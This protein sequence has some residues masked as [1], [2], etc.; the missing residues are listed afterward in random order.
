MLLAFCSVPYWGCGAARH[1]SSQTPEQAQELFIANNNTKSYAAHLNLYVNLKEGGAGKT[2][3]EVLHYDLGS[4][5]LNLKDF[6]GKSILR[7]VIRNDSILVVYPEE[8]E[9]ILDLDDDFAASPYWH[10]GVSPVQLLQFFDGSWSQEV[11]DVTF[12]R[13]GEDCYQYRT[14]YTNSPLEF[15][16]FKRD[17]SLKRLNF[18]PDTDLDSVV[19]EFKGTKTFQD[20]RSPDRMEVRFYPSKEELKMAVTEVNFELNLSEESFWF[21]IPQGS[22]RIDLE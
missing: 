14:H 18:R 12:L 11:G 4:Y 3:L 16:L 19:V 9:Y 15:S 5:A 21:K 13:A 10:W 17:A 8:G 1:V 2:E 20:H 6:W 22:K 7:A